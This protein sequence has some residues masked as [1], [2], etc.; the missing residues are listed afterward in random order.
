MRGNSKLIP[1]MQW[2]I[3]DGPG[4]YAHM[5]QLFGIAERMKQ[6]GIRVDRG[7][8]IE[9]TRDAR[10]RTAIFTRLFLKESK[11]AQSDLGKAGSGQTDAV[12][13]WFAAQGAPDVVFDKRTK[14]AQFNAAALTIYAEDFTASPFGP[15]AAALLGLRKAQ[16][17]LKFLEAYL[18]VSDHH[19]GR[20]HFGFNPL[21]TKGE[22]WSASASWSWTEG[23]E[24]REY[25]LNA[26]NVPSKSRAFTFAEDGTLPLMVSLR[27]CFIPDPGCVWIKHDYE[28]LEARLIAYITGARKLIDWIAA[29]KDIHMENARALFV[30][31]KMPADA[32][33]KDP[34]WAPFR[35]AA[36]PCMYALS[37]QWSRGDGKDKYNDL[38]KTLKS[39]FP[40]TQERYV[41]VLAERFFKLHPEIRAWQRRTS[42]SIERSGMIELP[43]TGRRLYLPPTMRGFNQALNFQMQSGGGALINRAIPAIAALCDWR[44][45]GVGLLAMVHDEVDTSVPQARAAEIELA[46]ADILGAPMDFGGTAA[47]VPAKGAVGTNWMDGKDIR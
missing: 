11:L 35:E 31:A 41:T 20:I 24:Q 33:K 32:K 16:T 6:Y 45:A 5:A 14:R 13:A 47:G 2:P 12:K 44:P 21:G 3:P 27:D 25:S 42:D 26:Q 28:A 10:A 29:D 9:H 22:R 23:G 38:F 40:N 34:R 19:G 1:E 37:Y 46:I 8:I 18:A 36:K 7:R 15:A 43:Q 4:R 39:I 17:S 30:E